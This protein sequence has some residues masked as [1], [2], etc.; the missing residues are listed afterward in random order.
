MINII[1]NVSSVT[2]KS[3]CPPLI[4]Y[5]NKAETAIIKRPRYGEIIYNK[6]E[7]CFKPLDM[8]EKERDNCPCEHEKMGCGKY[9]FE[10]DDRC[11]DFIKKSDSC[12][13]SAL[14]LFLLFFCI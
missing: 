11:M 14:L 9:S 12:C 5:S 6:A 4:I 13:C 2:D 1:Y 7:P 8:C 3:A 10:H